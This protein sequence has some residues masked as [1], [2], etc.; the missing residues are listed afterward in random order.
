MAGVLALS[1]EPTL[2]AM[3][4]ADPLERYGARR[5]EIAVPVRQEGGALLT[6]SVRLPLE[7]LDEAEVYLSLDGG[8]S[9]PVRLSEEV[10]GRHAATFDVTLPNI[11]ARTA[12]LMVRAGGRTR[13]GRIEVEIARSGPFAIVP[14]PRAPARKPWADRG[15]RKRVGDH[16]RV[17]WWFTETDRAPVELSEDSLRG[18]GREWSAPAPPEGALTPAEGAPV[19]R[20]V[21]ESPFDREDVGSPQPAPSGPLDR[22][23]LQLVAGP[24]PLRP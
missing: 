8:D 18:A 11:A 20:S 6:V 19:R 17:E 15:I 2:G 12:L 10:K 23:R 1:I 14:N 7:E 22:I 4:E 3:E 5:Q 24:L 13:R 21:R 9:F 16:A